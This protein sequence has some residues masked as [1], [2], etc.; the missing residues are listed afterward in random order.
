MKKDNIPTLS[1]YGDY[2]SCNYG[3]HCMRL[4]IPA[5]AKNKHG[6]TLFFSYDTLIAFRGFINESMHG[7]FVVKNTFSNTTGKHLNF[8]DGGR[9]ES[10]LEYSQF[11]KLFNKAIKNA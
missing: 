2:S 10:R 1:S 7:L 9:K 5:T 3:A 8:I 4:E 11:I 6:I